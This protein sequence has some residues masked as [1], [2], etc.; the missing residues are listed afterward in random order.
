MAAKHD[1]T[2]IAPTLRAFRDALSKMID[3]DPEAADYDWYA[4][5]RDGYRVCFGVSYC[6]ELTIK[7][8]AE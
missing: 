2:I 6:T 3:D 4:D 1:R 5:G 8:R 7:S